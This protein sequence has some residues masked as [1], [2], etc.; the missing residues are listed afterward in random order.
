MKALSDQAQQLDEEASQ[1]IV[2]ILAG[3]PPGAGNQPGPYMVDKN[4]TD[5]ITGKLVVQRHSLFWAAAIGKHPDMALCMVDL[6]KERKK[7][8]DPSKQQA[9]R[10]RAEGE[11]Q[12][13]AAGIGLLYDI[14]ATVTEQNI[15]GATRLVQRLMGDFPNLRPQTAFI[16]LALNVTAFESLALAKSD[17]LPEFARALSGLS[18]EGEEAKN[19]PVNDHRTAEMI[20]SDLSKTCPHEMHGWTA[21]HYFCDLRLEDDD[22]AYAEIRKVIRLLIQEAGVDV[23]QKDVNGRTALHW[24]LNGKEPKSQQ[25]TAVHEAGW[26][27]QIVE[28]LVDCGADVNLLWNSEGKPRKLEPPGGPGHSCESKGCK[29]EYCCSPAAP[30]FDDFKKYSNGGGGAPASAASA[31]GGS[32]SSSSSSSSSWRASAAAKRPKLNQPRLSAELIQTISK[33]LGIISAPAK[34]K[35]GGGAREVDS[36]SSSSSSSASSSS[37]SGG[38]ARK[39]PRKASGGDGGGSGRGG[40]SNSSSSSSSSSSSRSSS[41]GGSGGGGANGA[42]ASEERVHGGRPGGTGVTTG[43]RESAD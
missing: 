15:R 31:A 25:S 36:S 33:K 16:G 24:A 10:E 8:I 21:V 18:E 40:S 41:S 28:E 3:G 17:Q 32:S 35:G 27:V 26:A 6:A 29:G 12:F 38:E 13:E 37:S 20:K 2:D 11:K 23:N 1:E 43:V 39:R 9:F 19:E 14:A 4:V 5:P 30:S 22:G 34:G 42:S 7:P